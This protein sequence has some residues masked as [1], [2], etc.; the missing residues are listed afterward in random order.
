MSIQSTLE[1][2]ARAAGV[3]AAT[4]SRVLNGNLS[5][6]PELKLKV[7]EAAALLAYVPHA[8]ARALASNKTR[9]VASI[10]PTIDNSIFARFI[11]AI[12]KRVRR[13]SY[14]MMN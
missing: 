12:Q 3:S 2:V 13:D 8:S 1:D 5:V 14:G 6:R 10:L 11:E 4:V 9:R 7:E